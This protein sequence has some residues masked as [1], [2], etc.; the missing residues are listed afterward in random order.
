MAAKP[1]AG[2]VL[3]RDSKDPSGPVL[4]VQPS[5]WRRFTGHIKH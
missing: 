4:A 3:G 5:N 1:D 2:R